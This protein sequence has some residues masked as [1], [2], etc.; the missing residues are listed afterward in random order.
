MIL[1]VVNVGDV[2]LD[3]N[4]SNGSSDKRTGIFQNRKTTFPIGTFLNM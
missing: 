1:F 3:S 2:F 4:H